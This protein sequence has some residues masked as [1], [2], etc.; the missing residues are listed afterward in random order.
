MT[1]ATAFIKA[2]SIVSG[3]APEAIMSKRG[4]AAAV[5]ARFIA[6]GCIHDYLHFGPAQLG[7]MFERDHATIIYAIRQDRIRRDAEHTYRIMRLTTEKTAMHLD[8]ELRQRIAASPRWEENPTSSRTLQDA[9]DWAEALDIRNA[10]PF[11]DGYRAGV[12]Q[13]IAA[14]R[15]ALSDYTSTLADGDRYTLIQAVKS[16]VKHEFVKPEVK[17]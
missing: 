8:D 1:P 14:L 9:T 12:I 2:A 6:I 11:E 4:R 16:A 15:M 17:L 7:R 13:T 10:N 3:I 5:D